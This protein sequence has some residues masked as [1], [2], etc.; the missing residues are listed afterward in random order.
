MKKYTILLLAVAGLMCQAAT[1]S[2]PEWENPEIFAIGKLPPRATAWCYPTE[3]AALENDYRSSENFLSLDGIWSFR[4]AATCDQKPEGFYEE[5]Y[6]V[7]GWDEMPVPG[8]WELHGFGMPIYTNI[9]YVFPKNPPYIDRAYTSVGA[10]RRTFTLP[11]KWSSRR[12]ILHFEAGVTAMYIWVNGEK[13]GYS[14]VTKSPAEFDITE[15]VR[16]GENTISIEAY[17]WSDGSY[18]EDQDFWRLSG[19]DRSVFLY[20]T[21]DVRV[22]DMFV[23]GDLTADYRDGIFTADVE[24]QNLGKKPFSGTLS[25]TLL[26]ADGKELLRST[27]KAQIKADGTATLKFSR[28][29]ADVELWSNETPYLYTTLVTLR[30]NQQNIVEAT[31]CR[32][33]FRKVEIRD[34]QLL[35]N[36]K[37]IE[38]NGVNIHEHDPKT[39]H[40]V[41]RERMIEDIRL[42]KMFN[43]NAVRMSHYPQSTLW[44]DLC[45]Q[46]GLFVVDEANIESHGM[47]AFMQD[48]YD[49]SQHP[50]FRPEWYNAHFDRVKRMM[51]RDKNHPSVIIWSMGNESSNGPVFYDMYDWLKQRD[52]SRPVQYEQAAEFRN[53][54]IVCPMYPDFN[55]GM[56]EYAERTDVKRPY[57]MC[58]YAHAM[59][60]SLGNFQKYYDVIRSS[61]HMQGGFIWDWV[62]QGI[63]ATDD[64]GRKYY[65]YG[66]D[67]GAWMYTHDENFCCNGCIAPDRTP[68][69][70]LYE[71]KKVYQDILFTAGDLA[72]GEVVAQNMF[73]YR[74][75]SEFDM[76]WE[77]LRD[78][79]VVA[80]KRFTASLAA[81]TKA[82][83]TLPNL[84]QLEPNGEYML[85]IFVYTR[86]DEPLIAAGHEIAREQ[87]HL[88]GD[89]FAESSAQPSG[90]ITTRIEGDRLYASA[91]ECDIIFNLKRGSIEKY[92][93]NGRDLMTSMPEP[94]FWRAITDNDYGNQAHKR[95]NIWRVANL[96][97]M[98]VEHRT[99]EQGIEVTMHYQLTDTRSDY[100]LRYTFACDG[101]LRV[102]VDW[103]SEERLPEMMRFG[104]RMR[105]TQ[106]HENIEWYGRGPWENYSDRKTSTLIGHYT[107]TVSE[108]FY[109][110]V[111]PQESGNKCDVRWVRL[112]DNEGKGIMVRG[113]Q[114]INFTALHYQWEDID[115]GLS[116]KQMHPSDLEPRRETLLNIDLAQRGLG[117][118]HSWGALPHPEFRLTA[119]N[120]SYSYI[121]E[122]VK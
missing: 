41:S 35:V 1:A 44:Y 27:R 19:F 7:S 20:S 64:L 12:T 114:P 119:K 77:L 117:G 69:P 24:L 106:Q 104:M 121:I 57:I 98:K 2:T 78:G 33:G 68:H 95:C 70:G 67:F 3:Q 15:F 89:Y 80:D 99:V 63:E 94:Q 86:T 54:D 26:D 49:E 79:K 97:T 113:L 28:K 52:P 23:N 17:R 91:A 107:S 90:N 115:A 73:M 60:N 75:L 103:K 110:Y 48:P 102:D 59:G 43:I 39:G 71:V 76:R 109:T 85:N 29:V 47:G 40:V 10:Y 30:D 105:L 18:L 8:N 34:A 96:R 74:D 72:K 65:A 92:R 55:R 116:K 81:G 51:E 83:I 58:E 87:F 53:T 101:S 22:R 37:V 5:S 46:Y 36:G 14:E 122:P 4:W 56:R 120:Y 50:T 16:E 13:V 38:V 62:D 9:N 112:T 25:I 66:G 88:A 84:P 6:D 61:R 31:S 118:D 100:T 108:Q 32:T 42:M 111:R 93:S 21:A 11:E 45:D 82:T